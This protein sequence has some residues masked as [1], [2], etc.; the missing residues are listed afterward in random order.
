MREERA[1]AR[2]VTLSSPFI[3][4]NATEVPLRLRHLLPTVRT[5]RVMR[6]RD[7]GTS[8]DA[9]LDS[10]ADVSAS[11]DAASD[12]ESDDDDIVLLF[13]Q[14]PG[15]DIVLMPGALHA[16]PLDLIHAAARRSAGG[17]LAA[18]TVVSAVE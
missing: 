12:S 2:T 6:R 1:G 10:L 13:D 14:S 3:F 4:T 8:F 5:R 16:F 15:T 11:D 7:D 17:R 9:E 18:I